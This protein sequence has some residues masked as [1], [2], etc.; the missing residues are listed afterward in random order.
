LGGAAAALDVLTLR[1]E[2]VG[3][4]AELLDLVV[5]QRLPRRA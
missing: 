3:A 4:R 1:V 5:V 2:L